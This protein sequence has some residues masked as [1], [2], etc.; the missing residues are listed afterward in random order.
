MVFPILLVVFDVYQYLL[1]LTPR[2]RAETTLLQAVW[3]GREQSAIRQPLGL[4]VY[5]GSRPYLVSLPNQSLINTANTMANG[6]DFLIELR[7]QVAS[8]QR[9]G[10][11]VGG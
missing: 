1:I 4:E 9:G 6:K 10:P 8:L 11:P 5:V 7:K 2:Y 3:Q